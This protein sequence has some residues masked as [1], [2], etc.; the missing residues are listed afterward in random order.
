M[1]GS[2]HITQNILQVSVKPSATS[3]A[4]NV[5]HGNQSDLKSDPCL[6]SQK[7]KYNSD[8][9]WHWMTHTC[10]VY[11]YAATNSS[12]CRSIDWTIFSSFLTM[13]MRHIAPA[14]ATTP[15][16][17]TGTCH[18]SHGSQTTSDIPINVCQLKP[19][20]Y[21][22]LHYEIVKSVS[23]GSLPRT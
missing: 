16:L 4:K 12:V 10:V 14:R 19:N 11:R 20:C 21:H 22:L 1:K 8:R 7:L 23:D 9:C 5:Q 17:V 13:I 2:P 6:V 3:S 15:G 18:L